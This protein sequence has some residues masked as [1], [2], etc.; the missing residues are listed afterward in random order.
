M[1]SSVSFHNA[2][3]CN[4]ESIESNIGVK[5]VTEFCKDHYQRTK[6][7]T[8]DTLEMQ[9]ETVALQIQ[10]SCEKDNAIKNGKQ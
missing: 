4:G 9:K 8:Q 2:N 10:P 5:K 7:S 1:Q 6:T 3:L